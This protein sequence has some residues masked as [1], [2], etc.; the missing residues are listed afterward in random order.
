MPLRTQ[1]STKAQLEAGAAGASNPAADPA[2]PPG[3]LRY[4]SVDVMKLTKDVV[5]DQP[6]DA[7]IAA[8]VASLKTLNVTHIAVSM[9]MNSN[10]E[11]LAHGDHPSPRSIEQFT[12][13]WANAIHGAGLNVLWRNT[14]AEFEQGRT[15]DNTPAPG[16]HT[17]LGLYNFPYYVGG[18]PDHGAVAAG[19]QPQQWWLDKTKEAITRLAGY[20]VFKPGDIAGLLP[21]PRSNQNVWDTNW[22]FLGINNN[23]D[24][25]ASFFKALQATESSAFA[26]AG[27][28][29]VSTGFQADEGSLFLSDGAGGGHW[30]P[31]SLVN[32]TGHVVTDYYGG[33]GCG[34]NPAHSPAE[35]DCALRDAFGFYAKPIFM[36]EWADYW[37]DGADQQAETAYLNSMYAVWTQLVKEGKMDGFNYWGGWPGANESILNPDYSINYRGQILGS[38]FKSLQ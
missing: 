38:F 35:M 5:N 4:R 34:G 14:F 2:Q 37:H 16:A 28:S 32:L 29:G 1:A 36:G 9:P 21:E 6:S 12:A 20:G 19:V 27:V 24:A 10:A 31:A 22:N 3:K 15:V 26:A 18:D 11:F 7:T 8:V 33:D 30:Y 13:A 25:Y 17:I 23:P